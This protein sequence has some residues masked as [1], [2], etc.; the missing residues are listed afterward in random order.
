MTRYHVHGVVRDLISDDEIATV[1]VTLNADDDG[2]AQTLMW[3]L[4][5]DDTVSVDVT[6]IEQAQ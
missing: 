1:T 6:E 5:D 3:E 2:E 4:F